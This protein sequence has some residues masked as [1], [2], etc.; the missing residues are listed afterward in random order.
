MSPL[1]FLKE[2][3]PHVIK[4]PSIFSPSYSRNIGH[5]TTL[6]EERWFDL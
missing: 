2:L 5:F 3:V 1:S 4:I 6:R